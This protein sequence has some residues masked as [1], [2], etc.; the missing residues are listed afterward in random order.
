MKQRTKAKTAICL[1][2]FLASLF[3]LIYTCD[4]AATARREHAV[5]PLVSA[6]SAEFD[7]PAAM[8]LAVARAESDFRA[9]ALSRAGAKGLMQLMPDTFAWLCEELEEP[10]AAS[11]IEDPET[12][13]RFGTYYLSYLFE[14]F[15]NWRVALAAYNAGEGHVAEWLKDPALSSGGTLRRIPYPETAA[16]VKKA[17]GYYVDY[18]EDHPIKENNRD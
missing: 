17:L 10:H 18:L 8:I 12:N 5:L 6:A 13:I 7:V 3:F 4:R 9:D 1:L 2:L 14:K 11:K 15:G 16:Y